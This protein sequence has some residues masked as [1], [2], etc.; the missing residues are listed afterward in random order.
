MSTPWYI[1]VEPLSPSSNGEK[2]R[3]YIKWIEKIECFGPSHFEEV[4]TLDPNL[5]PSVVD[6]T[7]DD[8]D[9][10]HTADQDAVYGLMEDL[11]YLLQR[12]DGVDPVNI[13]AAVLTRIFHHRY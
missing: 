3:G 8:R 9:W 6:F 11:D 4:I 13:L 12:I 10:E 2:W 5:C 7:D 1:A